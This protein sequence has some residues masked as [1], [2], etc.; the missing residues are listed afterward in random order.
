MATQNNELNIAS[1]ASLLSGVG[2]DNISQAV[3]ADQEG[4]AS[5]LSSAIPSLLETMKENASTEEGAAS[6]SQALEAHSK[7][8]L[9]DLATFLG[10]V[11]A[12]DSEKIL[13]HIFGSNQQQA[14]TAL[15]QNSGLSGNQVS[16]IL[17]KLAPLLLTLLGKQQSSTNSGASSAG[18]TGLLSSVLGGGLGAAPSQQ[19]AKPD[20]A[21]IAL[22]ALLSG[23]A[24]QQQQQPAEEDNQSGGL[25]GGL[26]NLFR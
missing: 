18:V 17:I 21:S 24:Q 6:L 20:L 7:D 22:S 2:L 8:D 1:I 25:L 3:G 11:D 16:S 26:L 5:V 4:V 13:G 14:T 9:T 10:G 23:G 19:S 15:A 12:D